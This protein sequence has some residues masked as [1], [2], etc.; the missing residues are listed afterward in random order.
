M[1]VFRLPMD[2]IKF[3]FEDPRLLEKVVKMYDIDIEGINVMTDKTDLRQQANRIK[4][5]FN[6]QAKKMKLSIKYMHD[7]KTHK[8]SPVLCAW[9]NDNLDIF[10]WC[11]LV[12][13][14]TEDLEEE[15]FVM[16]FFFKG[17][18]QAD[19]LDMM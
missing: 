7:P 4:N 1:N 17:Y 18:K 8:S 6:D 14:K 5:L 3:R 9:T 15:V 19:L 2:S 10:G 16:P 13:P 12:K 11:K